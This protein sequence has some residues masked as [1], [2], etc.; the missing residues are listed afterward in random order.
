MPKFSHTLVADKSDNQAQANRAFWCAPDCSVFDPTSVDPQYT[1]NRLVLG[2]CRNP[3]NLLAHLRR[4]HFCYQQQWPAQL[5]G[6]LLD[7]LIV[8][9]SRGQ[10]L[11]HRMVKGCHSCLGEGYFLTLMRSA[12]SDRVRLGN[13]YS[14]FSTGTLGRSELVRQ[15]RISQTPVDALVLAN[16]FIEYSQLDQAMDVLEMAVHAD[17]ERQD[18]QQALLQLYKST[19]DRARFQVFHDQLTR[20]GAT[21]SADWQAIAND[22]AG[23]PS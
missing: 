5:F 23:R 7:F 19:G 22:F 3:N 10:A 17:P 12:S 14:V 20:S 1:L 21:L 18:I 15:K 4:I 9:Q 11:S 13:G 2:V 6:A 8:L 16:D